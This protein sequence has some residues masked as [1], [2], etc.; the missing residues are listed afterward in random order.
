MREGFTCESSELIY[1]IVCEKCGEIYVGETERKL[2]ERFREHRHSVIRNSIGK[3]VASHFNQSNHSVDD[4]RVLGLKHVSGQITRR[5]EEQRI[6]AMLGC[7][8]GHGMNVDFNFQQL[9]D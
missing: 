9:L 1:A 6:I 2:K 5:I 3:E 4:M 8:L 7:V